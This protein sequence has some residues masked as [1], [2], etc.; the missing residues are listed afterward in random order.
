VGQPEKRLFL[1]LAVLP[2]RAGEDVD[3]DS[4]ETTELI[5]INVLGDFL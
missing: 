4:G 5:K 2:V 1:W 3:I